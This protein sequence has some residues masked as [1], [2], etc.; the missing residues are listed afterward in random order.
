MQAALTLVV[1]MVLTALMRTVLSV[2]V[3][4]VLSAL[5]WITTEAGNSHRII[6]V[7]GATT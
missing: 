3:R 6:V 5:V 1:M 2:L 4:M 7:A